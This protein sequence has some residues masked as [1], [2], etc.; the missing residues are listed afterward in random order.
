MMGENEIAGVKMTT[1]TS[2]ERI[3]LYECELYQLLLDTLPPEYIRGKGYLDIKKM[4]Q[5]CG[6]SQF[7][8]LRWIRGVHFTKQSMIAL[9]QIANQTKYPEKK[10]KLTAEQLIPFLINA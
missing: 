5:V 4:S 8:I 10:G 9:L 7:S 2:N 3:S 6:F 1:K